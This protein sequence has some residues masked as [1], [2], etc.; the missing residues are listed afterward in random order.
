MTAR[1]VGKGS[2]W[3]LILFALPFLGIGSWVFW[4]GADMWILRQKTASWLQVPATVLETEF[5]T[6]HSRS[7]KGRSSTS[8]SV[9]CR[10]SYEIEGRRYE[11]TGV[12]LEG[13]MRSSDGYHH[14]RYEVLKRHRDDKTPVTAWVNPASPAVSLLFRDVTTSM[15]ALPMVGFVF[16]AAGLGVF[17]AG[18]VSAGR[19]R[20]NI[21][22]QERFPGRPWRA[23]ARWQGFELRERPLPTIFGS[24][25]LAVVTGAFVSVFWILLSSDKNA[26]FFAKAII[27]LITLLPLGCLFNA[28]Y[29]TIRYLKYG[30]PTLVF[31]QMP[32][33]PGRENLALLHVKT[34]LGAEEGV[35]L[36]IQRQKKEWVRHG[37]KRSQRVTV[38][39]SE[40]KT[41][42]QDY[43]DR[44][45]QGSAIPVRFTIP[46]DQ[47]ETSEDQE[48]ATVWRLIA[49]A[50]TPG[51]DFGAEFVLPVFRLA[52]P[53]LLETN[54]MLGPSRGS[55]R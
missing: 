43:A 30:S 17:V 18:A 8:Y 45:R 42:K 33:V 28:V 4:M 39:Y 49:K 53:D 14:T 48:P 54:P 19:K 51:V 1:S 24:L 23:D 44:S 35:E 31:S 47:P 10:Y 5:H 21:Q 11:G 7:S 34:H 27:G 2:S 29:R 20:K 12:G 37:S 55:V 50:A 22:L 3:F 36:T 25:A 41:V 15:Y 6:V 16:A 52:S 9:T 46:E 13:S 38:E 32:F 26:P 40:T